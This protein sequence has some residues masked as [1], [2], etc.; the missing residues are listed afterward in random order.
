MN[1]RFRLRLRLR[2]S[3][4]LRPRSRHRFRLKL[5]LMFML[6]TWRQWGSVSYLGLLGL[7]LGLDVVLGLGLVSCLNLGSESF[8]QNEHNSKFQIKNCEVLNLNI[9]MWNE[10]NRQRNEN[11]NFSKLSNLRNMKLNLILERFTIDDLQRL[12]LVGCF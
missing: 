9:S 7:G 2:L 5:R 6:K 12:A 10:R 3:V 8:A 11:N 4:R 1:L